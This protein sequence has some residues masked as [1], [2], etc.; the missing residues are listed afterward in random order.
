MSSPSFLDYSQSEF[1]ES[2]YESYQKD[3]QSVDAEWAKF[4]AGL[5]FAAQHYPVLPEAGQ[6]AS[7]AVASAGI[8]LNSGALGK[9]ISVLNL[10]NGYRSRGHLMAKVNPLHPPHP[11][12]EPELDLGFYG[13]SEA[14]LDSEFEAGRELGLGTKATLRTILEKV[15]TT[16]T[17]SVGVEFMHMRKQ[18]DLRWLRSEMENVANH[19][20]FDLDKKKRILAKLNEAEVFE[21]FLQTK[22]VGQNASP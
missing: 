17:G 11:D 6:T 1:I 3:P 18:E 7:A 10:I 12:M 8:G 19:P 16:Y 4:F 2:L 14:D 5:D 22:Y 21:K 20:T 15:Q 9:Q 13:L